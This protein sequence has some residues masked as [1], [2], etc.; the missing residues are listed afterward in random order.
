[1]PAN[2]AVTKG[3]GVL[4]FFLDKERVG[5]FCLWVYGFGVFAWFFYAY[6]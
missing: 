6:L 2:K 3:F 5:V 4:G 1:M